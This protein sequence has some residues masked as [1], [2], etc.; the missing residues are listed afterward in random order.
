MREFTEKVQPPRSVYLKWPFG[1]PLGEPGNVKLE[2]DLITTFRLTASRDGAQVSVVGCMEL[3]PASDPSKGIAGQILLPGE[4][5]SVID[6]REQS[7]A[8]EDRIEDSACIVLVGGEQDEGQVK[9]GLLVDGISDVLTIASSYRTLFGKDAFSSSQT[10]T[11]KQNINASGATEDA[12]GMAG[13]IA[14]QV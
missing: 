9:A 2:N 7:I 4:S 8:I 14:S 13:I 6:L 12:K 10:D 5:V 1:H 11:E 3:V